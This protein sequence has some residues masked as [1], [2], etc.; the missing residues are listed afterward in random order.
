[1][2]KTMTPH[3]SHRWLAVCLG[4]FLGVLSANAAAID[5]GTVKG[6]LTYEGK[7]YTLKHVYAWQP[8]AQ[9]DELWVYLTDAELPAAAAQ[10]MGKANQ[11]ANENR[12]RAATTPLP[13]GNNDWKEIVLHFVTK[14]ETEAVT[15]R[16]QRLPCAEPPCPLSGR[17]WLDDFKLVE[18]AQ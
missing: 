2:G 15:V 8:Y 5:T 14:A 7:V 12:L 16:V 4:I 18:C 10:S 9:T 13:N 1:M 11:L 6:Q 17:L 3:T